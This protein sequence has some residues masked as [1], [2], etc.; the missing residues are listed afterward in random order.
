VIVVSDTEQLTRVLE[1]FWG[2]CTYCGR[3]QEVCPEGAITLSQEYETATDRADDLYVRLEVFM[4][5]CQRCGRCF[6]PPTPLERMMSTGFRTDGKR[7]V[8]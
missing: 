5:P 1:F 3:C 4:G 7:D 2:R 8:Q 6:T